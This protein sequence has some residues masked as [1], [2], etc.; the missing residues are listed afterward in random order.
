MLGAC[1]LH[2]F[3]M[4]Q[5]HAIQNQALVLITTNTAQRKPIFASGP[6][7]RQAIESLYRIQMFNPFFL[8]A[9]VVMPDHCHLLLYVPEFGSISKIMVA[10]KR[11][12]SF[13]IGKPIWQT[14]FHMKKI[15]GAGRVIDYI[16]HNPVRRR[17]CE[18]PDEYPWSSASGRWDITSLEL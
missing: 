14:R 15:D 5:H 16:H 12:V 9:F 1:S 13:E 7:A 18:A 4:F 3:A 8:Y 11:A 6:C 10:W 17:L 2:T